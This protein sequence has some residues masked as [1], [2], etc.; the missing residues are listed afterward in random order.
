MTSRKE[1][2]ITAQLNV[3]AKLLDEDKH[4]AAVNLVNELKTQYPGE[5]RI[6]YTWLVVASFCRNH[7]AVCEHAPSIKTLTN[8]EMIRAKIETILS[9][10]AW[11]TENF[12]QA[13]EAQ[14]N[15]ILHF[16]NCA[17]DNLFPERQDKVGPK[18]LSL[19]SDATE[20]A[21]SIFSKLHE[22]NL[23]CGPFYGTLL[24][25]VRQGG[26]IGH[27][28]D[29]DL[30]CNIEIYDR[31]DEWFKDHGYVNAGP[32]TFYNYRGYKH[33][34]I[35][36]QIDLSGYELRENSC[37]T[38]FLREN[39][40]EFSVFQEFSIFDLQST[41]AWG[42]DLFLP[43]NPEKILIGL[44]GPGWR[45]PDPECI[46][47][48]MDNTQ[49]DTLGTK[50]FRFHHFLKIWNRGHVERLPKLIQLMIEKYP[51]DHLLSHAKSVL[52]RNQTLAGIKIK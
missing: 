9:S 51:S 4:H 44:Y 32:S 33:P 52:M 40:R 48:I 8:D 15:A 23:A 14:I 35:G 36:V 21:K 20:Y 30:M 31:V 42:L 12:T 25:F 27:D 37:V 26:V 3:V 16:V 13:I 24:G 38:G 10:S 7:Q 41:T 2:H 28:K 39:H 19:K 5:F 18:T 11:E 17:R 34:Q 22:D 49:Q 46:P 1:D 45:V 43:T 47:F 50:Y 6:I 29:I